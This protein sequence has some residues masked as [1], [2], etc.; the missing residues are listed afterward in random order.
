MEK[1]RRNTRIAKTKF[2][3]DGYHYNTLHWQN[4]FKNIPEKKMKVVLIC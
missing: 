1:Q 4:H 2:L 3:H